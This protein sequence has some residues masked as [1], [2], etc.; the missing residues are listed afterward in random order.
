MARDFEDLSMC[1]TKERNRV[2]KNM[3]KSYVYGWRREDGT[4]RVRWVV[5]EVGVKDL[6]PVPSS[7]RVN[8]F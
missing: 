6:T 1:K 2:V 3:G 7:T 8:S 5:D 4:G